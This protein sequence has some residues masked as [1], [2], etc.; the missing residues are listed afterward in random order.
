MVKLEFGCGGLLIDGLRAAWGARWIITQT[1]EVDPVPG[2]A[3]VFGAAEDVEALSAWLD[4]PI[5]W[6]PGATPFER[7]VVNAGAFLA[8]RVIDTRA[9][10]GH[11]LHQDAAGAILADTRA[12]A[13]Y[14]YVAAYLYAHLPDDHPTRGLEL[15]LDRRPAR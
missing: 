2:R 4:S 9:A 8:N 6:E 11:I 15:V 13:G 14:L 3:S 10:G 5:P 1:G 12:S 7:A